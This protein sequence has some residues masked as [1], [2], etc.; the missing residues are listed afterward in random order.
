LSAYSI[1]LFAILL[2]PP[3]ADRVAFRLITVPTEAKAGELRARILAGEP[4]GSVAME[5]STDGSAAS[6]GFAG[7]FART[8][9][10]PELLAAISGLAPGQI[11]PVGKMGKEFFLVE[12]VAPAE[13]EWMTENAAAADALKKGRGADAMRSFSKAVALAEKFGADDDRLAES[14]NGLA[15]A[16]ELQDDFAGSGTVY[17]RMLAIRWSPASNKGNLA[18]AGL[19]DRL[20]DLLSLAYFQGSDFEEALKKYQNALTQTSA[21]EALYLAMNGLLVKAELLPQAEDVMQRA[22]RAYPASRRA[23][24][25]EAEMYRDSGKMR[26]ALEVF[27]EA[28]QMKAPA[29]MTPDLDSLQ[30]SFIYQRIGGINTD[31]TQFDAAIAAYK[32]ALEISPK[33]ADARIALGDA[34]LRRDQREEA[35]AEYS[36]MMSAFPDRALPLYRYA[37]AC[38]KSG[39]FVEAT[40]AAEKAL[41]IDP[42]ERKAR[43]VRGQALMRIGRIEEGRKELEEYAKQEAAAQA[44]LNSQRDVIV[45]NRGAADLILKGR[46]DEAIALFQSSL[47]AHPD[48]T[49]LRLNLGLALSQLGR[50]QEAV[51]VF[52][53]MLDGGPGDAFL[54]Y[55]LLAREYG[56]L[57]DDKNAQKYDALYI[58]KI[59]AALE[60]ELR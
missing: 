43:F 11:S 36:K 40:A 57:K 42:M 17:R 18:V 1:V 33:N 45:S 15:Q 26:K 58:R 30:L 46:G 50:R 32:K 60:D 13:V 20:T 21:S 10:R 2:V 3:Q 37:D 49:T 24:Y 31:L 39:D 38:L 12:I 4:F 54:V 35:R 14:L 8:D 51:S 27:E 23:R 44:D 48:S 9:L 19:V 7:T 55:K 47:K 6:G 29:P 22:V 52:K 56:R 59:D 41:K 34:Y 28:S 53:G 5:N 16:Y 25:K